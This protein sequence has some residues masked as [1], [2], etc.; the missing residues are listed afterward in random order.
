M[1]D[2][3]ESCTSSSWRNAI[4]WKAA[5]TVSARSV[6]RSDLSQRGNDV[7]WKLPCKGG[8]YA[9]NFDADAKRQPQ[10]E[11]DKLQRLLGRL[12]RIGALNRSTSR[13]L[14]VLNPFNYVSMGTILNLGRILAAFSYKFPKPMFV[15]FPMATS[16]FDMPASLF[17]RHLEFFDIETAT[18]MQT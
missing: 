1:Q 15:D 9:H 14:N 4:R 16:V 2:L 10:P 18:P 6:L 17:A 8:A 7:I 12:R 3:A 13:L 5:E 11:I